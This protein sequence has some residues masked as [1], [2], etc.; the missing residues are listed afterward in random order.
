[1]IRHIWTLGTADGMQQHHAVTFQEYVTLVEKSRVKAHTHMLEH[2]YGNDAVEFLPNI[3][4]IL[5]SEI[6]LPRER[7]PFRQAGA[8]ESV[9]L[10]REGAPGYARVAKFA[11]IEGQPAPAAAN[12]EDASL[13]IEQELG[14]EMA[15]LRELRVV[16]RLTRPLEIGAAVLPV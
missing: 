11:E 3:A 13:R 10:L 8:G 9:L 4:V 2:S 16:E 1:G 14:R 6:E 15:L 7:A 5:Q 12:I